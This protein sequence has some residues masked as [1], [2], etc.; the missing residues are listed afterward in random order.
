ML[1]NMNWKNMQIGTPTYVTNSTICDNGVGLECDPVAE[2]QSTSVYQ[3]TANT[4]P[5]SN[6]VQQT[7][8]QQ[9]VTVTNY[10]DAGSGFST[11]FTE[12]SSNSLAWDGISASLDDPHQIG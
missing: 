5:K 1:T 11:Q 10:V 4:F 6:C 9:E 7:P 3:I 12:T 8:M 2:P